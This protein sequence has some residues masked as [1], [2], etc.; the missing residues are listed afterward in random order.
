MWGICD[1]CQGRVSSEATVVQV[2]HGELVR[3]SDG[4]P[5]MKATGSAQFHTLC[6]QC[7]YDIAA[8]VQ[9][10]LNPAKTR[11]PGA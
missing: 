11:A 2:Q 9:D 1:R 3:L 7:G 10:F 4:L 8:V 6:R 5:R